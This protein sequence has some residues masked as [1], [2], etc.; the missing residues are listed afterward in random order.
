MKELVHQRLD[1]HFAKRLDGLTRIIIRIEI[2][3]PSPRNSLSVS[4]T[5]LERW[6]S[7]R[8]RLNT[9]AEG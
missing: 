7:L 8:F 5:C 3:E 9:D 2:V 1:F 6:K 4:S